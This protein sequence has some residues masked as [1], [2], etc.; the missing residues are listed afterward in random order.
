M[1]E[2]AGVSGLPITALVSRAGIA[3][4]M[5]GPR[6]EALIARKVA[7]RVADVLVTPAV[8]DRLMSAIVGLLRAHHAAQPLSDGVPREEARERLFAHGHPAVFERALAE[9][10]EAGT[11]AGRD[12][13]A[14]SGHVLALSPDE[15]RARAAI[16][17]AFRAAGLKPPDAAAVASAAGVASAIADRVVKLL[18]RQ[19]VLVKVDALLFHEDAL[20]RLK[21]DVAAMK[22]SAGADAR[23]DVATFKDRFGVT[24]KFAIPLLEYLDRE[25]VTR[26]VGDARVV[27]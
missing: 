24:R 15:E 6:V 7:A 22:R 2:A 8:L 5:M 13:L 23:L 25:R 18:Q 14:L 11:I 20:K 27:L 19:K 3:P 4:G 9:L 21:Q 1:I 10:A 17:R 26:R 16:E 12:R